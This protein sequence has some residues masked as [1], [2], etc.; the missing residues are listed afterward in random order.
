MRLILW[1][2]EAR[3]RPQLPRPLPP[4]Q[5]AWR[6]IGHADAEQLGGRSLATSSFRGMRSMNPESLLNPIEIAGS[7]LEQRPRPPSL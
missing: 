1:E 4:G 7:P 2:R 5:P 3:A 6:D